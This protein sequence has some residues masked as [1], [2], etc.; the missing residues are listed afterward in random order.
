M[1]FFI[2]VSSEHSFM[3]GRIIEDRL[4][5]VKGRIDLDKKN[6]NL[7]PSKFILDEVERLETVLNEIKARGY[8]FKTEDGNYIESVF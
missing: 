3:L 2:K 1:S 5:L 4:I 7:E 6:Y 8:L